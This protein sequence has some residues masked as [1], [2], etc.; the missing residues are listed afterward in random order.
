MLSDMT[1]ATHD[2]ANQF[3]ARAEQFGRYARLAITAAVTGTAA[4]QKIS[5][6]QARE[7]VKA[8]YINARI[9]F[10]AAERAL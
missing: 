5:A 6:R 2:A 7:F 4:G 10:H 8:S 9:A 3:R 1:N